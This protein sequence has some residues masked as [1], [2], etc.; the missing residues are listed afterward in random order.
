MKEA[1]EALQKRAS[2]VSDRYREEL[3]AHPEVFDLPLRQFERGHV[4]VATE[5]GKPIGFAAL[6]S[7]DRLE[8]DG[9]FVEPDHWGMG[10]GRR[11]VEAAKRLAK[12]LGGGPLHVVASLEAEGFYRRCGFVP[13][14]PSPTRFGPAVLMVLD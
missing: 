14:G 1:L 7:G 12:E 11:L 9:L 10:V 6:E 8:L 13:V 5:A 3:L 2:L 4:L